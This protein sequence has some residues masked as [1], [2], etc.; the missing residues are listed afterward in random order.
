MNT[1]AHVKLRSMGVIL[2]MLV[3]TL[4][5]S[6]SK[7]NN[8]EPNLPKQGEVSSERYRCVIEVWTELPT[9]ISFWGC[10]WN[11]ILKQDGK[12]IPNDSHVTILKDIGKYP[13]E[14]YYKTEFSTSKKR[15]LTLNFWISH[16]KTLGV[17]PLHIS[18][19]ARIYEGGKLVKEENEKDFEVGILGQ[20]FQ[21]HISEN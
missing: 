1:S 8:E 16:N 4:L 7:S 9:Q 11:G 15:L 18:Y 2:A 3:L 20:N 10:T 6:C 5:S 13:V 17:K 14:K 12:I 21:A 19:K